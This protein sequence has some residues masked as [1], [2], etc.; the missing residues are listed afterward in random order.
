LTENLFLS[1]VFVAEPPTGDR[2]ISFDVFFRIN[3]SFHSR[4]GGGGGGTRDGFVGRPSL[5]RSAGCL[6]AEFGGIG[7]GVVLHGGFAGVSPESSCV[8]EEIDRI[9][10]FRSTESC[11]LVLI[12]DRGVDSVSRIVLACVVLVAAALKAAHRFNFLV[13]STFVEVAIGVGK[14]QGCGVTIEVSSIRLGVDLILGDPLGFINSP[15]RNP[16]FHDAY[17]GVDVFSRFRREGIPFPF[18]E[19]GVCFSFNGEDLIVVESS[20]N[21]DAPGGGAD[22]LNP[23][24]VGCQVPKGFR[25]E[26]DPIASLGIVGE[27]LVFS[28]KSGRGLA[29][30]IGNVVHNSRADKADCYINDEQDV[31]F[32]TSF[33]FEEVGSSSCVN[34]DLP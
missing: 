32:G 21:V 19:K 26:E 3:L 31:C 22:V 30:E 33:I 29:D 12:R 25:W 28:M 11:C 1:G 10:V 7:G 15:K 6:G 4:W 13:L 14:Y 8:R 17:G 5:L 20:T 16:V 23:V 18:I 34:K 2:N 24:G 27:V 9:A